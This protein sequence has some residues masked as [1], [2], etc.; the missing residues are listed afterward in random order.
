MIKLIG[1][2]DHCVGQIRTIVQP[3]CDPS[4]IGKRTLPYLVYAQRFDPVSNTGLCDPASGLFKLKRAKCGQG[5]KRIG[6]IVDAAR[7]RTAIDVTPC[8]GKIGDIKEMNKTCT[9]AM[10]ISRKFNMNKY[11]DKETFELLRGEF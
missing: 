11:A 5:K 2:P 6:A 3:I 9:N 1:F 8:F 7:I 10:E 4:I